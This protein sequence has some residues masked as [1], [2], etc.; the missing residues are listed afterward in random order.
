M[1]DLTQCYERTVWMLN[2]SFISEERNRYYTLAYDN[3]SVAQ[4]LD[5]YKLAN[6]ADCYA[7]DFT[8]R[9]LSEAKAISIPRQDYSYHVRVDEIEHRGSIMLHTTVCDAVKSESIPASVIDYQIVLPLL[10]RTGQIDEAAF[11]SYID[12]HYCDH[13]ADIMRS[14]HA[15]GF[16]HAYAYAIVALVMEG[17]WSGIYL[18]IGIG[19]LIE[20]QPDHIANDRLC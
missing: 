4:Q 9:T 5:L 10:L 13:F 8:P 1:N 3:C 2:A 15:G 17:W 11:L 6:L 18:A 14:G 16:S 19:S 7:S 12:N 20:A